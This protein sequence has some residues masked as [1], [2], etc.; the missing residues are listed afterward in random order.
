[1]RKKYCDKLL[2]HGYVNQIQCILFHIRARMTKS[3]F[4]LLIRRVSSGFL[5]PVDL[6]SVVCCVLCVVYCLLSVV[7]VRKWPLDKCVH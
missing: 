6:L 7:G 3:T 5:N 1:M 4:E 2:Q